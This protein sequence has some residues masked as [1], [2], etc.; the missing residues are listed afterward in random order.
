MCLFYS[1]VG[2]NGTDNKRNG[3]DF[4]ELFSYKLYN[5]VASHFN[6]FFLSVSVE[7]KLTEFPEYKE[8]YIIP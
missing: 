1:D 2:Y 8:P 6:H 4:L 3:H 5:T 7:H